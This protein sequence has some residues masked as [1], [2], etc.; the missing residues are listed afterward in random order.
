MARPDVSPPKGLKMPVHKVQL[1]RD[2]KL[3]ETHQTVEARSE[4]EA[5][6][7]LYGSALFK[8]GPASQLRAVV[9]SPGGGGSPTL[10]YER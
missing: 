7:K 9:Q 5:A 6:E 10:F 3:D 8:Q 1:M 4:K 2:G